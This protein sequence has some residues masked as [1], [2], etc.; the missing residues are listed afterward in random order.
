ME[1]KVVLILVVLGVLA[2]VYLGG[3]VA[4]SL[5]GITDEYEQRQGYD[6]VMEELRRQRGG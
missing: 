4:T 2:T 5:K 1:R 3:M 6:H